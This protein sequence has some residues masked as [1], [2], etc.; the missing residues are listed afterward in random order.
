MIGQTQNYLH[1]LQGLHKEGPLLIFTPNT[2]TEIKKSLEEDST[3]IAGIYSADS[4][5][6]QLEKGS[7][8]IIS[9]GNISGEIFA[10]LIASSDFSVLIEGNNSISNAIRLKAPFLVFKSQ[11]NSLQIQDLIQFEKLHF[12]SDVFSNVYEKKMK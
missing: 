4:I 2:E 10:G 5:P 6:D 11:W 9:M 1:Q 12:D 3:S 8:Y 7:I